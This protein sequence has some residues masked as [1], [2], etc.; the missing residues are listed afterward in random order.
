[1]GVL[2]SDFTYNVDTQLESPWEVEENITMQV[3]ENITVEITLPAG[4]TD[5]AEIRIMI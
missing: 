3:E 1:M 4:A 5:D 2:T